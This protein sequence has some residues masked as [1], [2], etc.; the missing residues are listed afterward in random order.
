MNALDIRSWSDVR[1][2]IHVAAPVFTALAV[3]SG[4][5]DENTA[6]LVVTVILALISPTLATINTVNGFR[7]WLYPVLG[8][9]SALLIYLGYLNQADWATWLPVLVLFIG[10]AVAAANTPTTID[11]EAH[12]LST[13]E[14]PGEL[15][16][17]EPLHEEG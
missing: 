10:P 7:L 6:T 15:G 11:G 13:R 12:V 9:V 16:T 5:T 3:A 17:N 4:W 8:A 2:F 1:A 14:L